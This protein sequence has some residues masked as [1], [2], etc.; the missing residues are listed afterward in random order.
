MVASSEAAFF[1]T[2]AEFRRWLEA[3][4]Q[5]CTELLVGFY[6]KSSRKPSMTYAEAVDE[7]LCF[8]WI[9]GVRR[10]LNADAYSVR[11]TPRKPKSQ[12][13][14][15]NIRRAQRLAKS[16]RM[17]PVGE[18]A[19]QAAGDRPRKYSYEQRHESQ[20]RPEQE[21]RFRARRGA[22][23]YFQ[24]QPPGYR[25]TATFWVVSAKKE[26][27]R[28]RRLDQLIAASQGRKHIDLLA[29][30]SVPKRQKNSG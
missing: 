23:D 24:S 28:H 30:Y 4:H 3:N 10:G 14:A 25:R 16:G 2:P 1:C 13:S 26:E 7:A 22:W 19:F 6:K 9:D 8:G 29:P 15:V 27:T 18:M 17:Q 11:F 12:W 5:A 20:F 21:R